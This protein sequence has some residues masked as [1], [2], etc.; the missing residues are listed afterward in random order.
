MCNRVMHDLLVQSWHGMRLVTAC[1]WS[2]FVQITAWLPAFLAWLLHFRLRGMMYC[3]CQCVRNTRQLCAWTWLQLGW[4][5]GAFISVALSGQQS[6]GQ[7]SAAAQLHVY[8][9][10]QAISY[11][12][13]PAQQQRGVQGA[14][15][16]N[17]RKCVLVLTPLTEHKPYFVGVA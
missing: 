13:T 6:S 10:E 9:R 2:D 8:V 3:K 5:T 11:A 12:H 16:P 4:M 7:E 17:A 15:E 1:S 14:W